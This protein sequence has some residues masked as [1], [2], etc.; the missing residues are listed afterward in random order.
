MMQE[1]GEAEVV[2]ACAEG[3]VVECADGS[4]RGSVDAAVLRRCCNELKDRIDRHGVRLR[5]AAV[6]G[7][8]DLSGLDI[9]FPLSFDNCEFESPLTVEGAQLYE[10]G[11]KGC[12]RLPGLLANGVRI[13]RDLD[14]SRTHVTGALRTSASTSKQSAIWLCESEIGG[15][16]HRRGQRGRAVVL[17]AYTHAGSQ[18]S[19]LRLRRGLHK[20]PNR[21]SDL[22]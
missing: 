20:V 15:R 4:T 18:V 7:S 9:P 16:D 8:L 10:L 5:N 17:P 21:H 6:T 13:R 22:S 12:A 14:L 1:V 2:Q 19:R 3:R 11:L